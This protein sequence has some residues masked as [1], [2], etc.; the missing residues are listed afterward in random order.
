MGR[1]VEKFG[2]FIYS[3]RW[4]VADLDSAEAWLNKQGVRSNRLRNS[5]LSCNVEDTYGAP[6][7]FTTED[8]PGDP[9]AS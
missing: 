2:N 1:H 6:M 7:F 8:I 4:K 3:L 9:F 5:L